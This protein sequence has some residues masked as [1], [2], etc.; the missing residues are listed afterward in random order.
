M[1]FAGAYHDALDAATGR[2]LLV[3]F[4][5]RELLAIPGLEAKLARSATGQPGLLGVVLAGPTP[6]AVFEATGP[7][8]AV[9]ERQ[10]DPAMRSLSVP[11][12]DVSLL[13][14]YARPSLQARTLAPPPAPARRGAPVGP[15]LAAA[16]ALVVCAGTF[17][18]LGRFWQTD[19]P[20]PSASEAAP[21]PS[22]PADVPPPIATVDRD[23]GGTRLQS[24]AGRNKSS[25]DGGA[26]ATFGTVGPGG[27]C[28]STR[29]CVKHS[30]CTTGKVC[31]CDEW[32]NASLV[33]GNR[34]V[35]RLSEDDCGVCGTRCK[36]DQHCAWTPDST[37]PNAASCQACERGKT[38]CGTPHACSDLDYDSKNCG[39][40]GVTCTG[41][42]K[43]M[44]GRCVAQQP[45]G[46]A[47]T[48]D[49]PC[50]AVEGR[51]VAYKCVC[52]DNKVVT[53]SGKCGNCPAPLVAN[54]YGKCVPR[55]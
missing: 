24:G 22:A 13:A 31:D 35:Y 45:I 50:G 3:L 15:I 21:P 27:A 4:F 30:K 29:D 54:M 8:G 39:R 5:S 16:T 49:G 52:P 14:H 38:Y 2:P 9:A 23:G 28:I 20:P 26:A 33:C 7:A 32:S 34:C 47:C 40:C 10:L 46:G 36:A 12:A 44:G 6:H 11:S 53:S 37:V 18:V 17:V 1:G 48:E 41:N 42:D 51:C 19:L 55:P 43:C 25:A